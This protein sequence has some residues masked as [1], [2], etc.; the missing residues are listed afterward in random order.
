MNFLSRLLMCF[1]VVIAIATYFVSIEYW[2]PYL[3]NLNLPDW[4]VSSAVITWLALPIAIIGALATGEDEE[5][6]AK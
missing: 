6:G 3:Q 4:V 1:V 2:L 5:E